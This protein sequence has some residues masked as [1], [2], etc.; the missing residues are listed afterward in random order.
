MTQKKGRLRCTPYS[1]LHISQE[2]T[3]LEVQYSSTRSRARKRNKNI[4]QSITGTAFPHH[5]GI[6]KVG[7]VPASPQFLNIRGERA[8]SLIRWHNKPHITSTGSMGS[9]NSENESVLNLC[10]NTCTSTH[11]TEYN[12]DFPSFLAIPT[13][14]PIVYGVRSTEYLFCTCSPMQIEY[15]SPGN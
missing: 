10:S 2:N 14:Y 9:G 4:P 15:H 7:A 3:E 11:R 8:L 6:H 13:P 5:N 12:I 1:V